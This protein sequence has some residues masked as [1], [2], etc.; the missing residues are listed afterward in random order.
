MEEDDDTVV[1][2]GGG[3]WR[4]R[5]RHFFGPRCQT[6]GITLTSKE[7]IVWSPPVMEVDCYFSFARHLY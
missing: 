5:R 4:L 6:L 1:V 3:W 2:D 7:R